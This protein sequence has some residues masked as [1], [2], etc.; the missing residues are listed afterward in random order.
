MPFGPVN[1][2]GFNSCMMDFFKKEW[3]AN[4]LEVMEE[5][6]TSRDRIDGKCAQLINGHVHLNSDRLYC[7]TKSIID[8]VLIWL[9]NITCILK[10]FDCACRV[11]QKYRVSFRQ[12]KCHFLLDKVEYAGHDLLAHG[13]CPAQ[14]KFNM[15][16]N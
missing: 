14:S 6:T 5:Y 1:A 12:D 3:N 13:N 9:I 2:P 16:N 7:G 8:D 4:F 10:Y 11:F 15:I